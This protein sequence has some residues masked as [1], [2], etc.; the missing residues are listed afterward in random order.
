[1]PTTTAIESMLQQFNA[2][3]PSERLELRKL[4]NG[5]SPTDKMTMTPTLKLNPKD[6]ASMRWMIANEHLYAGEWIALDGDRLIAHN[7]DHNAVM[8]AAKD[9][10]A[11]LPIIYFVEPE[12]ERSFLRV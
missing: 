9:D 1:M 6:E 4:I 5:N 2:L 11:D 7:P 8:E 12:P 10:G 3:S